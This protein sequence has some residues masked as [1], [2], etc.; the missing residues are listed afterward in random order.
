MLLGKRKTIHTIHKTITIGIIGVNSGIGVTHTSLLF[1]QYLNQLK[2]KTALVELNSTGAFQSIQRAYEGS[3]LTLEDRDFHMKGVHYYKHH[4]SI[5]LL[6]ILSKS[7][8]YVIMDIG[9]CESPY[10]DEFL[11]SDRS[12]VIGHAIEWKREELIDFWNHHKNES[13]ASK[14][15]FC[16]LF[17]NKQ[18]VKELNK[19]LN[20]KVYL[21][22]FHPDPF[23]LHPD[24]SLQLST[25]LNS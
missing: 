17:S 6:N 21:I 3:H 23:I 1:A 13:N 15:M 10:F 11:R 16:I 9:S 7:Y 4:E 8:D 25:I 2:Q 22:P 19:H 24:T 5:H 18:E 20:K 14:W 12:I